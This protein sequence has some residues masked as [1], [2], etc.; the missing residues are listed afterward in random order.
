MSDWKAICRVDNIP[1]LG[2]RRVERPQAEH[3]YCGTKKDCRKTAML[4]LATARF[5]KPKVR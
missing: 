5:E 2:A 4:A 1:V 3:Y